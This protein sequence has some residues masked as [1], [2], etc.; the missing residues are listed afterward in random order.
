MARFFTDF[1][2][3]TT[4]AQPTGWAEAE[5]AAQGAWTVVAD[6][7]A[8]GGKVLRW[9][10]DAANSGGAADI[11]IWTALGTFASGEIA[12]RYRWATNG[13]IQRPLRLNSNTSAPFVSYSPEVTVF[14]TGRRL[15]RE[16]AAE[17]FN[18]LA[19]GTGA[20]ALTAATWYGFRLT[21]NG[22]AISMKVWLWN[23]GAGDFGES[24]AF[25]LAATDSPALAAG[26]AGVAARGAGTSNFFEFDL[27]GVA[28]AAGEVAPLAVHAPAAPAVTVSGQTK[29]TALLTAAAYSDSDGDAQVA[30]QFRVRRVSD[31]AIL[32]GPVTVAAGTLTTTATGLPP[33]SGTDLVGEARDSDYSGYG[34]W[35]TSAAFATLP[36]DEGTEELIVYEEDDATEWATCSSSPDH[37]RPCLMRPDSWGDAELDLLRGSASIGQHNLRVLDKR[38]GATDQGSGWFSAKLADAGGNS[39]LIGH[40]VVRRR[41]ESGAWVT[42]MDGVIDGVQLDDQRVSF[43]LVV[44]DMRE[45]E[46]KVRAFYRTGTSTV[47]PRGAIGGYGLLPSGAWLIPPSEPIAATFHRLDTTVGYALTGADRGHPDLRLILTAAMEAVA[48]P[49]WDD[50]AQHQ[51]LDKCTVLWRVAGS[52]G[53]YT[54]LVR[55]P[56]NER[57]FWTFRLEPKLFDWVEVED[58]S[59]RNLREG[60]KGARLVSRVNMSATATAAIPADGASIELMVRY[61]GPAT[62]DFPLHYDGTFGGLLAAFYDGTYSTDENGNPFDPRIRYDAAAVAALS[63]PC[64]ARVTETTD[65]M[66]DW[67]EKNIYQPLGAAPAIVDGLITPVRYALPAADAVLPVL[68]GAVVSAA[69]WEHTGSDA[70]NVVKVTYHRDYA[71]GTEGDP[72]G[73]SSAGDGIATREVVIEER[74]EPS[75]ALLGEKKLEISPVTLRSLGGAFGTLLTGDVM[76][77]APA[78]LARALAHQALDRFVLGGQHVTA[79]TTE[80]LEAGD[81]ALVK[82]A[83]L[84]DYRTLRRSLAADGVNVTERLAQVVSVSRP[85]PAW[86]ELGLV[87]AGAVNTPAL[88]PTLGALSASAAGIVSIPVTAV[89]AGT[90]A[91]VQY[92]VVAAGGAAPATASGDWLPVGRTAAV[93]TLATPALPAGRK[94]WVRARGVVTGERSSL[95]TVPVAIT[96]AQTARLTD[97]KLRFADDGTATFTG[98][99]NAYA[100]GVRIAYDIHEEGTTASLSTSIDADASL[101]TVN[102]PDLVPPE[103]LLTADVTGYTGWSGSAATGTAGETQRVEHPRKLGPWLF[104]EN[105]SQSSNTLVD[106]VEFNEHVDRV[107]FFSRIGSDPRTAGVPDAGTSRGTIK[108][109]ETDTWSWPVRDGTHYVVARGYFGDDQTIYHDRLETIVITGVG[110]GGSSGSAAPTDVPGTPMV[111]ADGTITGPTRE[112]SGAWT[113]TNDSIAIDWEWILDGVPQGP[114]LGNPAGTTNTTGGPFDIGARV[115]LRVRYTQ[116]PGYE[117][118]WATSHPVRITDLV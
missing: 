71:L 80:P 27:V 76:D 72:R 31:S 107:E 51:I 82:L 87:D 95:Y 39:A 50:A 83:P 104:A 11:L 37:A 57:V 9:I 22:T 92:A 106:Q 93:A 24:T 115:V 117:G 102:L 20:G 56:L 62:E 94:V 111:L 97:V 77:E 18:Q 103:W 100:L 3:Y 19:S 10:P 52:G 45:R 12:G 13:Y 35:G 116:G 64:H 86:R 32:F 1:S 63:T 65:D 99:P 49:V 25:S 34:S 68:D 114:D 4:G 7:A 60:L 84:P 108:T 26:Y 105:L 43:A 21:K 81:W 42:V 113:N 5:G 29:T 30:R 98:T 67:V 16:T 44:K 118:A 101:G 110:G 48:E 41:F 40:R 46:R 14:G 88:A 55:M 91:E 15:L 74:N 58:F 69:G 78:Q 33:F 75:V 85:N 8:T 2:E 36:W 54:E 89:P 73:D 70:V 90:T 79:T 6:G 66:R 61:D 28:T 17:T 53:A 109:A 112:V 59:L 47:L 38:T 23:A 96:L